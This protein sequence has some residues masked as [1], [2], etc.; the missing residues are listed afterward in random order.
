MAVKV[1][2]ERPDQRRHHRVTAPLY[3]VMGGHRV[4]AADWSLGGL[5]VEDF[6]GDIP[7]IGATIP[8]DVTLPFQG[9]D[10]SF[11]AQAEVVR[12]NPKTRMFALRFTEIG[13]RE[14]ELMSHFV[15]E[16]IRGAMVDVEETIQR[17]DVP[18]TPA[19]LQPDV[20]P[21]PAQMVKNLP[22]RRLPVKTMAVSGVYLAL[23]CM[24]FAYAAILGYT[25]FFRME[26]KTAVITAPVATIEAQTD[27]RVETSGLQPGDPVRSGEVMFQV[28]DRKL[29]REIELAD[30]QIKERKAKLAYLKQRHADELDRLR[31]FATVELKNVEQSKIEMEATAGELKIARRQVKRLESLYDRGYATADRLEQA[32][33]NVLRLSKRLQRE[34]IEVSSRAEL[35]K[36]NI[37][38]R[39]YTGDDLI[40]RATEFDAQVRLAQNEVAIA[41]R[42]L[43]FNRKQRQ[44]QAIR[45]PFDGTILKLPHFY[46]PLVQRGDVI[47][48]VE[49]RKQR[50][51]KAF[52][53]QDEVN[54]IGMG[55]EA[56]LY[57][58]AL[59]ESVKGRVTS[60]DRTSGFIREQ[61]Q[62]N[63]P[64]YAWR[65]PKD[66]SAEVTIEFEDPKQVE[67]HTKFRS[68]LPVVVVF[69]QRATN[70]LL[71]ALTQ[72]FELIL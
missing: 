30:L 35:A 37:G 52:L 69:E 15:E 63:N 59:G 55:D 42:Q 68:G 12:V 24:V 25:N 41:E 49:Q 10:V 22:A 60:I 65:G 28:I 56:L 29:E 54:R 33:T 43:Q 71:S 36:D 46:D 40:G 3:V 7:G 31:G 72:K 5:R 16:L 4:R 2:R 19:S 9:F 70:A 61:D 18:V 17:I 50:R 47:A 67:D 39:L 27:G 34:R 8:L 13:E 14:R 44:T 66:R 48:V 1:R 51:V 53:N 57:I 32:Q 11:K 6:P 20:K 62:R 23:G 26:I 45:A 21:T 58:P 38:R 64:G